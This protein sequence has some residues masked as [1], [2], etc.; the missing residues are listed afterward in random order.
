MTDS[1]GNAKFPWRIFSVVLIGTF[2]GPLGGLMV[3]VALPTLSRVYHV[4]LNSTVWVLLSYL[5]T[6]TFMLPIVG[7]LGT[8]YGLKR[9]YVSGFLIDLVGTILCAMAPTTSIAYL[10]G[11]RVIQALG[12]VM[13]FALF[14]AIITRYVPGEK[15]G[16][17][18]GMTGGMVAISMLIGFPLAGALCAHASWQWIFWV[19][20]PIQLLG[21]FIG[22]KALPDDVLGERQAFNPLSVISWLGMMAGFAVIAECFKGNL[23]SSLL[24]WLSP[25]WLACIAV[26]IAAERGSTP[27]FEYSIFR[28]RPFWVCALGLMLNN[29]VVQVWLIF[30]TYYLEDYLGLNQLQSG[31][32]LGLSLLA[33][34]FSAPLAGRLVDR[35]GLR[36]PLLAGLIS[37]MLA[38]VFM[39]YGLKL[40]SMPLLS[41]GIVLLGLG[42]GLFNAP[43]MSTMMSTVPDEQQAKASSVNSLTRNVGFLMGASGGALVFSAFLVNSGTDGHAYLQAF[44]SALL[45]PE[46]VPIEAFR[47]SFAGL[48]FICAALMLVATVL[49]WTLPDRIERLKPS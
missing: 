12:S 27:L 18:F 32:L 37:N 3:G 49:S 15:R 19:Q 30:T 39:A 21:L 34:F 38:M 24:I 2:L 10:V 35:I 11:Y 1:A 14:S 26:F 46:N 25:A 20:V 28:R 48:L 7:R 16:M 6:T 29:F 42:G 45:N 17:A 31:R 44:Q 33:T 13:V 36:K 9:I 47:F 41:T 22:L 43:A 40:G 5:V 23:A 4:D 8:Q